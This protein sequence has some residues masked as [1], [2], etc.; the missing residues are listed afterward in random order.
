MNKPHLIQ[1]ANTLLIN[2]QYNNKDGLLKGKLG[3]ALFLYHFSRY[4]KKDSYNDFSDGLIDFIDNLDK[5]KIKNFHEGLTGI[6]WG[7]DHLIKNKFVKANDDILNEIDELISEMSGNDFIEEMQLD[8]PIFSKGLYFLQRNLSDQIYKTLLQCYDL[9][10]TNNLKIPLSY[11]NSIFYVVNKV[12]NNHDDLSELCNSII[13]K[14]YPVILA[15]LTDNTPYSDIYTL[16]RNIKN[17]DSPD[18]QNKWFH[19]TN[20]KNQT[21]PSLLETGWINFIYT[22][23]NDTDIHMSKS[24]IQELIDNVWNSDPND[25]CLYNGLTGIG[26]ELLKNP[27]LT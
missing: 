19:L 4:I 8:I 24:Q 3:I 13:D 25:L 26:F 23:D 6:G 14:L 10:N 20:G 18:K 17:L 7:I 2:I 5:D 11:S 27:G 16:K 9:L 21:I 12:I 22:Y 15:E 1:I